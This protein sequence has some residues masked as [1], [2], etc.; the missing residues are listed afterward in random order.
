[1]HKTSLKA[2]LWCGHSKGDYEDAVRGQYP[3][4]SIPLELASAWW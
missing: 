3:G 1:M 4:M 2:A